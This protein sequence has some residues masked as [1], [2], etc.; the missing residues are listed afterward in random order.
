MVVASFAVTIMQTKIVVVAVRASGR[1]YR[2]PSHLSQVPLLSS[3]HHLRF[4]LLR[5][6]SADHNP[7][8]EHF[9]IELY[10]EICVLNSP[11]IAQYFVE[12]CS[13]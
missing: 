4:P 9:L 10:F 13:R 7:W 6:P 3:R 12:C 5:E 2:Q 8:P 11:I 1:Q